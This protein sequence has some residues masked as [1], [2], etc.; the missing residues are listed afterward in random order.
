MYTAY[1]GLRA[2]VQ[3]AHQFTAPLPAQAR[4]RMF[5]NQPRQQYSTSACTRAYYILA[6]YVHECGTR[7]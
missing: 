4:L 1:S 2:L 7:F 3:F 5:I 6:H